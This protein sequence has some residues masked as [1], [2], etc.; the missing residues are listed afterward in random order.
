MFRCP[1]YVV[2]EFDGDLTDWLVATGRAKR[3]SPWACFHTSMETV[4]VDGDTIGVIARTIGGPYAVL[5]A[6]QLAASG[7]R[8]ILGLTS[9]G[10]VSPGLRIPSLVLPTKA[11]RDEGTSYHYLP[12]AETVDGDA[13][14]TA[15]LQEELFGLGLPVVAGTVWTH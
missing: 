4:E 1:R 7:A 8:V 14:L 3:W 6:E 10:Q 12:A 15:V 9:A 13:G 2:L 11:L 5:V